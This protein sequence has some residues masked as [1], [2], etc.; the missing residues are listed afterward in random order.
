LN[1]DI[2]VYDPQRDATTRLTFKPDA[3][4]R[5]PSWMPDGKHIVFG[6]IIPTPDYAIWWVRADG[7]GQPEKLFSAREA[8]VPTSISPDGRR[9]AFARLDPA[10]AYDIWTLPLD[11]SDAEHPKAG[12]PEAF[13]V[14]PGNQGDAAFSPDGRWLA[15]NSSQAGPNQ[16]FVRPF[17]GGP[18]AGKWQI[19]TGVGRYPVWSHNGREL[20]YLSLTD[21]HI[22]VTAY[23]ASGDSFAA[24]KPREWSPAAIQLPGNTW[25]MD[26]APDG[27]R[28]AV[29]PA[30]DG[31]SGDG[32]ATVH[33]TVL[34]NFFDELK[35]RAPPK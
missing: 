22:M 29:F 1:G 14:E 20:F 17:P 21:A 35:L 7:S 19:S 34:L 16:I 31:T 8:L 5:C 9:I 26:L 30:T 28:V 12:R 6:Q 24:E 15:Y 4:N 11:L 25:P 27:K 10:T 2:S 23:T 3:N 18:G 32:K 33:V 13:L